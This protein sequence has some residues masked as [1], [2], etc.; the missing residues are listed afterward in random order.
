M[1][2]ETSAP[3]G[4]APLA[5]PRQAFIERSHQ[6]SEAL[7]LKRHEKSGFDPLIRSDLNLARER[8]QRLYTH[9]APVMQLLYEQIVNTESMIV[10]TDAQGTILH[11]VGDDGFLARAHRVALAPGE[12]WAEHS[13]GTNAIGTALFEE[14]ATLIHGGEHFMHAN[15]FLTCSASP[16]F[17]PRGN[18][19]GVLDVT[20]DHRGYHQHTMGLVRMSA[21]MIE[22]HWLSDDYNSRLRLH[23]HSRPEFIGTLLEGI[24]VVSPEGRLLGANRAA[25][26]QLGMSGAE[27]R[28]RSLSSLLGTTPAAIY[29]HFR[30]PLSPPM[31]LCLPT[32]QSLFVSA[33]FDWPSRPVV[34][35]LHTAD[36]ETAQV[37]EAAPAAVAADA[38]SP[39]PAVPGAEAGGAQRFSGL[40]YLRTG[41][42]Q[43]E[44]VIQKVRRVLDRGIPLLILGETG[45]G[46]ELLARAVHHDSNRSRQPF[47]AVNCA[48]IPESLIEAELFGYEEGAF[49]GARRK[50]APGRLVQ[51]NGGTLFLDEIG[52]MPLALQAR[53][54]RALQERSVT[55]LGSTKS[56]AVDIAVIGATHRNLREMIEQ[57]TFR[58]DL[59]YRLNGLALRLPALR[60]RSDL[61]AIV[62]R[63]LQAERPQDTPELS[64]QVLGMFRRYQ[65]PGNIRQLANV[66]RT[67]AVMSAGERLVTTAHLS[68]DFL[69]DIQRIVGG[70]M[71]LPTSVAPTPAPVWPPCEMPPVLP[72]PQPAFATAEPAMARTLEQAEV[73]MIRATLDAVGG[74]ISLASKQLGISRNTIYR[75]LRWNAPAGE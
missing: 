11:A 58:E 23:F 37:R 20:G 51:A 48:S 31:Q 53:L 9:A 59:Y 7:G 1:P 15:N 28:S 65:W 69:E 30:M 17:D 35:G 12:N 6:R 75:K 73:D 41:D 55:P 8:N 72:A 60:E 66:L 71:P 21:R 74:N 19:L 45:T 68:D 4:P 14:T 52:D 26:D 34:A 13:K 61:E 49:T 10:L 24:L 43:L 44:T 32:G 54:L 46:K 39:V 22:N 63:I 25:L 47:V 50:G 42:A 36:V 16:I 70:V 40:Q 27:L 64:P 29:D 56:I 2:T 67:A 5:P 3:A 18:M 33:R 62:R 57:Q 38:A